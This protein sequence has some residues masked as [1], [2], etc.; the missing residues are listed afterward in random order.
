MNKR[1]E[2]AI[3]EQI[4][5]EIWSAYLY[6]SMSAYFGAQGFNGFS[7]WFKVQWQEELTHAMKFFDY[8]IERGSKPELKPIKEVPTQWDSPL[9]AFEETLKHEKE[10]TRLI[11][12]LMDIA[13]EEKDHAAKGILQ[14][15][16]DEQ[17][18]EEANA[19]ELIDTLK[20]INGNG[21]GLFMLDRELKQRT[22]V[23][24]TKKAE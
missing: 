3:N 21:N 14:W 1:L 20:L 24:D 18:E 7:N 8:L 19:Q 10:V 23:D 9:H 15:F 22:F 11:N 13:I 5:A 4:N 16:V 2:Q 12:N 17:V 6:L